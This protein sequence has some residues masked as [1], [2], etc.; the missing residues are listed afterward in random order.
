MTQP[1]LLM[2]SFA[3]CLFRAVVL[4]CPKIVALSESTR[5]ITNWPSRFYRPVVIVR[6]RI[7]HG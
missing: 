5:G 7:I 2:F 1:Y 6:S 4:E 3:C